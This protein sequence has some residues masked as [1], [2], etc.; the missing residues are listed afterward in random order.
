MTIPAI[1]SRAAGGRFRRSFMPVWR[2]IP[3]DG[4][5]PGGDV[6]QHNR[7]RP[8]VRRRHPPGRTSSAGPAAGRWRAM[9]QVGGDPAGAAPA[10]PRCRAG[11]L[12]RHTRYI[13]E[14]FS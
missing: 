4:P 3:W 7:T 9:P 6:P 2:A 10:A 1:R 11:V 14:K 8:G 13:I 12:I 5:H